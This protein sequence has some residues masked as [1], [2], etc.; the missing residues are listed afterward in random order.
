MN[1]TL[2]EA[3]RGRQ[4][5]DTLRQVIREELCQSAKPGNLHKALDACLG[6]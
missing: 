5:A 3:M 4:I 2:R 6:S 1:A